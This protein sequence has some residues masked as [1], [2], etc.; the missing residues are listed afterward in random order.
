LKGRNDT[1]PSYFYSRWSGPE[2]VIFSWKSGPDRGKTLEQ[3]KNHLDTTSFLKE[4]PS[5]GTEVISWYV[6]MGIDQVVTL[7]VPA[8]K[9]R[10]VNLAIDKTAWGA[11]RTEFY[12]TYDYQPVWEANKKK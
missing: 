3:I 8:E 11:F 9:L 4:F 10:D 12:P 1:G 7:R 6:M 2:I 5:E